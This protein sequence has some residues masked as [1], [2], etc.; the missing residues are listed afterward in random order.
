MGSGRTR[1]GKAKRQRMAKTALKKAPEPRKDG[2]P[3][4][5]TVPGAAAADTAKIAQEQLLIAATEAYKA[6]IEKTPNKRFPYGQSKPF[7]ER[8]PGVTIPAVLARIQREKKKAEVAVET[9]NEED[10][11]DECTGTNNGTNESETESGPEPASESE[12]EKRKRG[13]PKGTTKANKF[14]QTKTELQAETLVTERYRAAQEALPAGKTRCTPGTF[15]RIVMEVCSELNIPEYGNQIQYENVRARIQAGPSNNV[16]R[17]GGQESPLRLMEPILVDVIVAMDADGESLGP[18]LVI[19]LVMDLIKGTPMEQELVKYQKQHGTIDEWETE[20]APVTKGWYRGF[21]ERNQ[22]EIKSKKPKA[23]AVNRKEWATDRNVRLF[24]DLFYN[25]LVEYG[26]AEEL[27][28]EVWRDKDDNIVD[29]EEEAFGRKTAYKLLYPFMVVYM[30]EIGNNTSQKADGNVGGERKV[31]DA[32]S[33]KAHINASTADC[34]WTNLPVVAGTGD[35]ILNATIFK[36]ASEDGT[37]PL[38][39]E[40]GHDVRVPIVECE[41]EEDFLKANVGPGKAFPG[42][43]PTTF[44][45]YEVP[46]FVAASPHGGINDEILVRLMMH[47]DKY[48]YDHLRTKYPGVTPVFLKDGHGTRFSVPYLSYIMD[49]AH[50]WGSTIGIPNW[51]NGWQVG[52]AEQVNGRLHIEITKIKRK[53]M[54]FKRRLCMSRV[55]LPSDVAPIVTEATRVVF[56]D[57]SRQ[58][59]RHAIANRGFGPL[60]YALLDHPEIVADRRRHEMS[61]SMEATMEED[62]THMT[63]LPDKFMS[64]VPEKLPETQEELRALVLTAFKAGGKYLEDQLKEEEADE[65]AE[66]VK[67]NVSLDLASG[68]YLRQ[69]LSRMDLDAARARSKALAVQGEQRQDGVEKLKKILAGPYFR[70]GNIALDKKDLLENALEIVR[71]NQKKVSDAQDKRIK[72]DR[73]TLLRVNKIQAK[74]KKWSTADYRKMVGVVKPKFDKDGKKIKAPSNMNIEELKAAWTKYKDNLPAALASLSFTQAQL[75]EEELEEAAET[76]LELAEQQAEQPEQQAEQPSTEPNDDG[77]AVSSSTRPVRQRRKTLKAREAEELSSDSL[78][79]EDDSSDEEDNDDVEYVCRTRSKQRPLDL[80][81]SSDDDNPLEV[82]HRPLKRR[83]SKPPEDESES[84]SETES[85]DEDK[86]SSNKRWRLEDIASDDEEDD[87][88]SNSVA[89]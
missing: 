4:A 10:C 9:V 36:M 11:T 25:R 82:L 74:T 40:M 83:R 27:N 70:D 49:P 17:H 48:V 69:A 42:F 13:R 44:M 7:L 41:N 86:S 12:P 33:D 72:R 87:G 64:L 14:C 34:R 81:D 29:T 53:L 66:F 73:K 21:L 59:V 38:S 16:D 31:G 30:D 56:S 89:V 57:S 63:A 58:S 61:A 62:L 52:D 75:E 65:S 20:P 88:V 84:E 15:D 19:E 46:P 50:R 77:A 5:N 80:G 54:E 76:A 2:T 51:T 71:R 39:V 37:V 60:N 67:I 26:I 1:Y 8:F 3:R 23:H 55:L 35:L 45:G 22:L 85:D 6:I 43:E 68:D 47:L 78:D 79:E 24:Y 32:N 28:E 18:S